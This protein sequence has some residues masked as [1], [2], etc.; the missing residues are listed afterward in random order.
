MQ[1]LLEGA[2]EAISVFTVR[3]YT[4]SGVKPAKSLDDRNKRI[5]CNDAPLSRSADIAAHLGAR[6]AFQA[7]SEAHHPGRRSRQW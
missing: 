6:K 4:S 2:F 7:Y 5:P 3:P 1:G